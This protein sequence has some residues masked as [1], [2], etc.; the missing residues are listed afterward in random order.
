MSCSD[1][2]AAAGREA[3]AFRAAS[4]LQL[5]LWAPTVRMATRSVV[6]PLGLGLMSYRTSPTTLDQLTGSNAAARS[7]MYEDGE[8]GP[9]LL[10][11]LP[12]GETRHID[13]FGR[14]R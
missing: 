7:I 11:S 9:A 8:H 12:T 5:V 10:G 14:S 13:D 1:A 2:E 4:W 6:A 3:P